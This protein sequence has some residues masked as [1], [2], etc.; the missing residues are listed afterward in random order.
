MLILCFVSF[1]AKGFWL[2]SRKPIDP[3]GTATM[4]QVAE[5][6][7]LDTPVLLNVEQKGCTYTGA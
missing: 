3:T 7:G 5:S 4:L 6:L 1:C 2:F